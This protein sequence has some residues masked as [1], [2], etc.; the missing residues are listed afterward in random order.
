MCCA[1]ARRGEALAEVKAVAA[2]RE[3]LIE[4]LHSFDAMEVR[5]TR[6]ISC[7]VDGYAAAY[8]SADANCMLQPVLALGKAGTPM[9]PAF[10]GAISQQG[11]K[12]AAAMSAA[13]VS[14]LN[15]MRAAPHSPSPQLCWPCQV[16]TKR[17]VSVCYR[18]DLC[19]G[20]GQLSDFSSAID[21]SQV[22]ASCQPRKLAG[23][24]CAVSLQRCCLFVSFWSCSTAVRAKGK[25]LAVHLG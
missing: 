9:R 6:I 3:R 23:V 10:A 16:R 22:G 13:I 5:Q 4:T 17:D 11:T 15:V 14:E 2:E 19:G 8:A 1:V 21:A 18:Q 20:S 25:L 7:S 24:C 12:V